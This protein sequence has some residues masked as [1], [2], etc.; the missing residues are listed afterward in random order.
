MYISIHDPPPAHVQDRRS[1][2]QSQTLQENSLYT[3]WL[4]LAVHP[5]QQELM[6]TAPRTEGYVHAIKTGI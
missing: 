2:I 5:R 3:A 4:R 1:I 6:I